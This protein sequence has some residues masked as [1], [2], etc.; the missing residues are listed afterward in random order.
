[1][2]HVVV[3]ASLCRG[4]ECIAARRHSAV[5]TDPKRFGFRGTADPL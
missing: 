3:A 4:A 5:A 2:V 1:M